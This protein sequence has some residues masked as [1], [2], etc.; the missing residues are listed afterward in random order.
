M[1]RGR[2]ACQVV[3]V[4]DQCT[5]PDWRRLLPRTA[6]RRRILPLRPASRQPARRRG[7]QARA[8][9]LRSLRRDRCFRLSRAHLRAGA[10][11][12]RR[13]GGSGGGRSCAALLAARRRQG[14]AA[15]A[16]DAHFQQG[17]A[18]RRAAPRRRRRGGRGGWRRGRRRCGG[19]RRRVSR[20]RGDAPR[21]V[22][23]HLARAQPDLFQFPVFGAR[24]LCADH[25]RAHR[26]RGHR[27]HGRQGLR[28]LLRLLPARAAPRRAALR[29]EAA[30]HHAGRGARSKCHV[31][32][33][34]CGR[35][36]AVR[37]QRTANATRTQARRSS[38]VRRDCCPAKLVANCAGR[39]VTHA[40]FPSGEKSSISYSSSWCAR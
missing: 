38:I 5:H 22:Q 14:R 1:D 37:S 9:R 3:R 18:R 13:R 33:G 8:H 15:A 25:A 12:A 32:K 10:S 29:P 30:G 31:R 2:A 39:K 21:A 6:P 20:K 19:T 11:D 27:A 35:A 28:P 40:F 24:V 16:A 17:Q 7:G 26:A 4:D 34:A 23:R 36:G